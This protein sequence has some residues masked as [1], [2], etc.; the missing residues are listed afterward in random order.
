MP[1]AINLSMLLETDVEPAR[2]EERCRSRPPE[3]VERAH[4]NSCSQPILV[5]AR[6]VG[7]AELSRCSKDLQ[8]PDLARA[9]IE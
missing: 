4:D 1:Q 7:H 9:A 8:E 3:K 5:V 6:R 2:T